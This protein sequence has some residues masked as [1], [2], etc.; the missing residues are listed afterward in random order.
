MH[1]F[2]I[3]VIPLVAVVIVV[4][5]FVYVSCSR[6]KR[7][8]RPRLGILRLQVRNALLKIAQIL[9]TSLFIE[10]KQIAVST[11][12]NHANHT[13]EAHLTDRIASLCISC[14]LQ[15][16]IISFRTPNSSFIFD[17]LRRSIK[18]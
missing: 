13:I 5:V 18:L 17:R 3:V 10:E 16:G 8:W 11:C 15:A 4:V 12:S 7:R 1:F 14:P 2:V 6:G 9:Y